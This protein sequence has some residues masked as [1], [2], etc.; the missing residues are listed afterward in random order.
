[1]L[2]LSYSGYRPSTI[3]FLTSIGTRFGSCRYIVT[4]DSFSHGG[5]RIDEKIKTLT[6]MIQDP[7]PD[8]WQAFLKEIKDGKT[9]AIELVAKGRIFRIEN[10]KDAA[11]IMGDEKIR[12]LIKPI[13]KGLIFLPDDKL[14]AFSSRIEKLGFHLDSFNLY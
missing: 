5:Y 8:N 13:G 4:K 6:K 3:S 7:M 10:E 12:T 9:N 1:M 14:R 2:I 11:I